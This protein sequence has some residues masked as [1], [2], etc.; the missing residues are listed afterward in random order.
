MLY[1]PGHPS[2]PHSARE[3]EEQSKE[4]SVSVGTPE[5]QSAERQRQSLWGEGSGC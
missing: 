2:H 1:P 5:R 4:V 3:C